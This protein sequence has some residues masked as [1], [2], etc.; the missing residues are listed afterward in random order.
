MPMVVTLLF[1]SER[2]RADGP[3]AA[4]VAE[5][6]V[7]G[8]IAHCGRLGVDAGDCAALT[9]LDLTA[10][11]VAYNRAELPTILQA[12]AASVP[13]RQAVLRDANARGVEPPSLSTARFAIAANNRL[14]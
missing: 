6:T 13:A 11:L 14:H 2:M 9:L 3:D 8:L 10:R 7:A 4:A 1:G 12:L 5:D